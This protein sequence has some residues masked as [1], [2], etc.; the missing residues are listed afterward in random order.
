MTWGEFVRHADDGNRTGKRPKG[1]Q[2]YPFDERRLLERSDA[3][4]QW[5][6]AHSPREKKTPEDIGYYGNTHGE[7]MVLDSDGFTT[8]QLL[9]H[10]VHPYRKLDGSRDVE[11][12]SLR[13]EGFGALLISQKLR[14]DKNIVF[15][16]LQ[17]M[18]LAGPPPPR[19]DAPEECPHCGHKWY[20]RIQTPTK[21]CNRCQRPLMHD[22]E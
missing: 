8:Q 13:F 20:K 19:N 17:A 1:F 6:K 21:K 4:S 5:L 7:W 14:I 3:A 22:V 11:I 9:Q 2:V 15:L 10:L 12:R 18:G 16:R